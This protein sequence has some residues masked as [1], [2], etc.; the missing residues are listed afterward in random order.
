MPKHVTIL[1]VLLAFGAALFLFSDASAIT[2]REILNKVVEQN[3]GQN[4]RAAV[5][6]TTFKGKKTVSEHSLWVIQRTSEDKSTIFVDFEEPADSKGLRFLFVLKKHGQPEA[7]MYLPSTRKTL[8]L[9]TDDESTDIGGT[10]LTVDD[11]QAVAPIPGEQEELVGEER[12]ADRTCYKI[13]ITAPGDKGD[14][15]IWVSKD[16]FL[17]I[18]TE[19]LTP[20]GKIRRAFHVVEFFRTEQGREFPREEEIAIPTKGIRIRVRQE[21]A[22]FGIPIPNEVMDPGTFGEY[23]WKK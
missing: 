18:K 20:D 8:P 10:G 9:A 21:N 17:V 2:P 15:L 23:Q 11:F 13:R 4:F 16:D 6:V 14:R 7:Y 5:K 3:F 1:I 19:Q 22:L 12:L